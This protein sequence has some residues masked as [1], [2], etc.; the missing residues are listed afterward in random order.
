MAW[1]RP[2]QLLAHGTPFVCHLKV[3][4]CTNE[5]GV[6]KLKTIESLASL[7][8]KSC[9]KIGNE[10]TKNLNSPLTLFFKKLVSCGHH[11]TPCWTIPHRDY[12]GTIDGRYL[13][14]CLDPSRLPFLISNLTPKWVKDFWTQVTAFLAFCYGEENLGTR[15]VPSWGTVAQN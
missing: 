12:S 1:K 8:F 7:I 4:W 9:I 2:Q 3:Q 6:W 14:S 11:C 10:F 5:I 13:C 15:K